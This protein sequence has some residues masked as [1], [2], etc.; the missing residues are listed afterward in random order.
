MSTPTV[1]PTTPVSASSSTPNTS[2]APPPPSFTTLVSSS[3][4]LP[5]P[6]LLLLH[7]RLLHAYL[8]SFT[9]NSTPGPEHTPAIQSIKSRPL[10]DITRTAQQIIQRRLSIRCL[11]AVVVALHLLAA[12]E[13]EVA[14]R[15]GGV[16]LLRYPLRFYSTCGGHRYWHI[17]LVVALMPLPASASSL[18]SSAAPPLFGA[19][20]L[21]RHAP[22]SLRE[23]TFDSLS[24]L[25]SSLREEYT[26]IGHSLL[27]M[28][29]G[30]PVTHNERSRATLDWHFLALRLPPSAQHYHDSSATAETRPTVSNKLPDTASDVDT[31][32]P[33]AGDGAEE[34]TISASS[35]ST[36]SLLLADSPT[37]AREWRR[38]FELLDRY[39]V[40]AVE[41]S[42]QMAYNRQR[43][44]QAR[45]L[46]PLH[47]HCHFDTRTQQLKYDGTTVRRRE[48]VR[49]LSSKAVKAAGG[50]REAGKAAGARVERSGSVASKPV[51]LPRLLRR[52]TLPVQRAADRSAFAV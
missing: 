23:M 43:P 32:E 18:S 14:E 2:Y 6:D 20:S 26:R 21:S 17:L 35:T 46:T 45:P 1:D 8:S 4:S 50:Q 3:P 19:V 31:D 42:S 27:Q 33:F 10:R 51:L 13:A 29:V 11:E 37:V 36:A 15:Y 12:T 38:V 28:T 40:R 7:L 30:L 5:L 52:H 22:L 39:A 16:R 47:P 24:A 48:T 25:C 44:A 9:Y 49:A 41:Y 34:M